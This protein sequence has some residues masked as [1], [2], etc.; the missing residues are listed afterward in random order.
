VEQAPHQYQ[1]QERNLMQGQLENAGASFVGLNQPI[2][3]E[4]NETM[5]KLV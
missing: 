2:A 4:K 1:Q 3:L 5:I